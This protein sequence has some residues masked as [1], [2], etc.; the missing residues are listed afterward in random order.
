[1][2]LVLPTL[3]YSF[4]S[5]RGT[6]QPLPCTL[7]LPRPSLSGPAP[8]VHGWTLSCLL[9]LHAF[10]ERLNKT[11]RRFPVSG[12]RAR[13]ARS[14]RLGVASLAHVKIDGVCSSGGMTAHSSGRAGFTIAHSRGNLIRNNGLVFGSIKPLYSNLNFRPT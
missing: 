6:A 10:A 7:R 11:G 9:P 13:G 2:S 4:H 1:M 3:R 5:P 12:V 8:S 14:E